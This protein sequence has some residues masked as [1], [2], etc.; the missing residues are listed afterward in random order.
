MLELKNFSSGQR[1]AN[2]LVIDDNDEFRQ[3][4]TEMLLDEGYVV[5]PAAC[6]DEAFPMFDKEKFDL[7]ICD[8]TM[9]FTLGENFMEFEYSSEVGVQTIQ[10]LS[11]ALPDTRVIAVSALPFTELSEIKQRLSNVP[12]LSKPIKRQELLAMAREVLGSSSKHIH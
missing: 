5:W 1:M 4:L 6:P 2:I 3:D 12:L 10:Q 9:P 7:I 11:W 8:L